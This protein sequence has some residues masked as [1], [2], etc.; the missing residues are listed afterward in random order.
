MSHEFP[1]RASLDCC[2][3]RDTAT[4]KRYREQSTRPYPLVI[5]GIATARYR[6]TCCTALWRIPRRSSLS[7]LSGTAAI[8][9]AMSSSNE[10]NELGPLRAA[11]MWISLAAT[12]AW[13]HVDQNQSRNQMG[14]RC[15]G[16]DG[17]EATQ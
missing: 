17:H 1:G 14:S 2:N 4:A 9:R 7:V 8:V 10:S 15:C 5:D 11:S 3:V 6:Q 12:Y 16:D 13:Q